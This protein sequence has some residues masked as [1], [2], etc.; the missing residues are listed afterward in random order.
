MG[1][2]RKNKLYFTQDTERAIIEYNKSDS[3]A[4]RNKIYN[5]EIHPAFEK[6]AENMIHT[7][8]FY[9]FDVPYRDV[10]HNVV[11]F[12]IEK[13][14]KYTEG[15]GK[16]FSY[17]SIVAK[18]WL[19]LN[20]NNNY[21]KIKAKAPITT[22]DTRRNVTNEIIRQEEMEA[23]HDFMEF[24]ISYCTRNA[25]NLVSKERDLKVL[26][27]LLEI[28]RKRDNIENFNKKALYI[29][30]REMTNVKTGY[31]TRVVNVLKAKYIELHKDYKTGKRF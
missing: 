11:T 12:L 13:M 9:Y 18:N 4:Y 20:N 25:N 6:L 29:M 14:P 31:I 3:Y 30:V 2:K 17:F 22:I 8:K 16:A 26:Y 27:A 5:Q 15:K 28:F 24:F 10:K 1:R 23:K 19:I 7:F 21:K